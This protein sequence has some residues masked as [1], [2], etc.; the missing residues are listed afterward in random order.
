MLNNSREHTW[1][2]PCYFFLFDRRTEPLFWWIPIW[3]NC[4]LRHEL[5]QVSLVNCVK[6]CHR[7]LQSDSFHPVSCYAD[8]ITGYEMCR[9][10]PYF[11]SLNTTDNKEIWLRRRNSA[12]G[13]GLL[14]ALTNGWTENDGA[15]ILYP[16]QPGWEELGYRSGSQFR[17]CKLRALGMLTVKQSYAATD[18]TFLPVV[19]DVEADQSHGLV[20]GITAKWRRYVAMR[21]PLCVLSTYIR[22]FCRSFFLWNNVGWIW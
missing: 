6:K 16:G 15:Q 3:D 13:F 21:K 22:H 5:F 20:G 4:M 7:W 10:F 19:C 18:V 14:S 1:R 8:C 17:E 12:Q 9:K 2:S 11:Q